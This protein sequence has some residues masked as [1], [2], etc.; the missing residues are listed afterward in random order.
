MTSSTFETIPGYPDPVPSESIVALEDGSS[1][2]NMI[3]EIGQ[4]DWYQFLV[5]PDLTATITFDGSIG[6]HQIAHY[7]KVLDKDGGLV[8]HAPTPESGG[9]TVTYTFS[10]TGPVIVYMSIQSASD[11]STPSGSYTVSLSMS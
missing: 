11:T 6:E 1:E 10:F 9:D 8:P 4:I 5:R 3:T 2:T 7:F